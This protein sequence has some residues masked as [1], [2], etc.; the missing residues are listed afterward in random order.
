[1]HSY[2]VLIIGSGFA[3]QCAAINLLKAGIDDFRLL[4]RRE[5]Y[6]GTWCQNT[7]PGAAVDIPSPLYSLSSAPYP[8]T[9]LY[10]GQAELRDY[11]HH[12]IERFA[13]E[14]RIE[15]ST[16]VDGLVWDDETQQWAV[17][18]SR[19]IF[20][21]HFVIN[22]SGPLS[23]AKLPT[24]DGMQ[25]FRGASFHSNHWD[26]QV[27]WRGKRVAVVGS[28][29]SAAQ[30]IPALAGQVAELHVFQRSAHWVLPRPDQDFSAFER[31]LL[32]WPPVYR[33]LRNWVYLTQ[34]SRVIGFK[35]SKAGIAL[36]ERMARR[37]LARQVSDSALRRRLTPDFTLGCKR[38]VLSSE[39]YPALTQDNVTLHTEA[40]ARLD[41][42]G[43]VTV[44]HT[45]VDLDLI[46]WATGFDATE[47]PIPYPV[48]GRDGTWL[49]D[50][51]QP[52]PRA[53]QG[54]CVPGFPNL[55]LL[56]GPNT[57]TGHTSALFM[58]EAQMH[59]VM[60]C[61]GAVRREKLHSIEVRPEAE[62]RYMEMIHREMR[63]TV[64]H[65]GGCR[66][67]YQNRSG[68]VVAMFPGFSCSFWWM[69][70]RLKRRDH[71]IK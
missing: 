51:W 12:V 14:S 8:W 39:L 60:A 59:Y 33:L 58:L 48:Q 63:K 23:Q 69:T 57:G 25:R 49:S 2:Q 22:A 45:H 56:A 27:D 5:F 20:H 64:W 37:H 71:I 13:L 4:E 16:Q 11:T 17:H 7:Y 50:V 28:G 46:V 55:F 70:R 9:R 30:I 1:M 24:F 38:V 65:W 43:I 36:V 29:A 10:A 3:G 15:L 66:S 40:I 61:I 31:W 41:E 68:T 44:S 21:S 67:W 26:H 42:S 18:T 6:G 52:F 54:T 35:Y 19:G 47:Q 32:S 53:Y 34:E 62:A